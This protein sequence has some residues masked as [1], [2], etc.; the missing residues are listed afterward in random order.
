MPDVEE[1]IAMVSVGKA[2]HLNVVTVEVLIMWL[3]ED[4][5]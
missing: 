1:I 4:V 5:Q 2:Y 3:M